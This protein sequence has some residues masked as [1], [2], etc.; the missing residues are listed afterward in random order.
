L[1]ANRWSFLELQNSMTDD[2]G[3]FGD[4]LRRFIWGLLRNAPLK[5]SLRQILRHQ[6]CDDEMHFL[7]LR[8]VG[9]IKGETRDK[10]EMRCRLYEEYFKNHL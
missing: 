3:P 9:L 4:H 2:F 10:V 1:A 5:E 8:A 7:R 6:K